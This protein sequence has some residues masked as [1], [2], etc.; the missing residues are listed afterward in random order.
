M[1]CSLIKTNK[2]NNI[3]SVKISIRGHS[4]QERLKQVQMAHRV[5]ESVDLNSGIDAVQHIVS[6]CYGKESLCKD[7][8]SCMME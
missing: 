3:V 5:L 7:G 1:A 2:Y 4:V 6:S 8:M